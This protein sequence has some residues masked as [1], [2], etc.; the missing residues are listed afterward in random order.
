M[1]YRECCE[2]LAV[3]C[4]ACSRLLK[5]ELIRDGACAFR[6]ALLDSPD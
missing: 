2:E 1:W 3:E 4:T 6:D 5:K